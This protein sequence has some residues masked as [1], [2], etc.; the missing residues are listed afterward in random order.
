MLQNCLISIVLVH[1]LAGVVELVAAF[2]HEQDAIGLERRHV[3]R[4][5]RG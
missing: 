3:V 4:E 2:L 1:G 5:G